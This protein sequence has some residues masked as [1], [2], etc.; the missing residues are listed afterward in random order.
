[1]STTNIGYVDVISHYYPEKE[2]YST[3]FL[4]DNIV[5]MD[6]EPI[7]K[8]EL[9]VK[10]VEFVKMHMI[11]VN[12]DTAQELRDDALY[13]M[14]G[15]NS[16]LQVRIYDEKYKAAK[17][18]NQMVVDNGMLLSGLTIP[19]I[20]QSELNETGENPYTLSTQII[21]EYEY[22]FG[23]LNKFYGT[24]EGIRRR[25][26]KAVTQAKSLG[27]LGGIQDPDFPSLDTLNPY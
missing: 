26:K 8:D 9:D 3:G 11:D 7:P 13:T 4:Y 15:T 17:E 2:C 16:M 21:Q 25:Y 6:G 20:L 5:W 12:W 22:A 27:E 1:M 18:Y 24:I 14:L 23:E 19:D 10:M